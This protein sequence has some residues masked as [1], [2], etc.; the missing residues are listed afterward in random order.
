MYQFEAILIRSVNTCIGFIGRL[1]LINPGRIS[2]VLS[3]AD[4]W[5]LHDAGH[6]CPNDVKWFY[7][8]KRENRH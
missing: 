4:P 5:S 1:I 2:V 6:N 3:S 8:E 7:V